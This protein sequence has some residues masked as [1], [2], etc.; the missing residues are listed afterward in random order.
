VEAQGGGF[1][2][3]K[4]PNWSEFDR[5]KKLYFL[6]S[7]GRDSTALI[8]EAYSQGIDGKMLFSSTYYN[9]GE[10]LETLRRL[11][12]Y[13]GYEL[14]TVKY[15]G[16]KKPRDILRNSFLKIPD[17]IYFMTRN[18]R[19]SKNAFSC[20]RILKENPATLF[21][22]TLDFD[23]TVLAMGIKA[24][25]GSIYRRLRLGELRKAGTFYR[26]LVKNNL[27][28]YYPLR[29][30]CESDISFVLSNHGFENTKSSGCRLCPVFCLFIT[31][32]KSNPET[33]LRSNKFAE[34][35][36][37]ETEYS[38]QTKLTKFCPDI[39]EAIERCIKYSLEFMEAQGER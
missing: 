8:L 15:H 13:T 33:W 21:M 34:S 18:K 25:D 14:I 6:A 39:E 28:Y 35:L 26:R 31:M 23:N 32:K 24:G 3:M 22:K 12:R 1:I 37:I 2:R 29:D 20:C 4:L 16:E 17:V 5:T 38:Q 27:L 11:Q 19:Y 9:M 10:S 7:G 36:G 30:S